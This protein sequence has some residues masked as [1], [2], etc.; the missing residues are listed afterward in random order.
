[1]KK[2]NLLSYVYMCVQF[3]IFK[4]RRDGEMCMVTAT[5]AAVVVGWF[6]REKFVYEIFFFLSCMILSL[7]SCS[8]QHTLSS[9]V[10]SFLYMCLMMFIVIC[11]WF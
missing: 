6:A 8:L 9:F 1:M 5:D 2:K 4:M 3:I 11:F 7:L 10:R